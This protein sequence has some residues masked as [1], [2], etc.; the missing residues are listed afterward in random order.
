MGICPH[1]NTEVKLSEVLAK[2]HI[3]FE[4]ERTNHGYN[5]MYNCPNCQKILGFALK[6]SY[7]QNS[8]LY[9]CVN[10]LYYI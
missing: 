8:Q 3:T 10:K 2:K 1:C 9:H 4:L 7:L 6:D 5:Y